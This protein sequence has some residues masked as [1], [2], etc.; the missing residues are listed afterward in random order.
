MGDTRL[1]VR[2]RTASYAVPEGF[3]ITVTHV[4]GCDN[5]VRDEEMLRCVRGANPKVLPELVSAA[6]AVMSM[7]GCPAGCHVNKDSSGGILFQ[8]HSQDSTFAG[9]LTSSG[10]STGT[11]SLVGERLLEGR[12]DDSS[13]VQALQVG[14]VSQFTSSWPSGISG[15]ASSEKAIYRRMKLDRSSDE[16]YVPSSIVVGDVAMSLGDDKTSELNG[17]G[18]SRHAHSGGTADSVGGLPSTVPYSVSATQDILGALA[19]YEAGVLPPQLSELAS[20]I[21]EDDHMDIVK[22]AQISGPEDEVLPDLDRIVR[23]EK[24]VEEDRD[25]FDRLRDIVEELEVT[26]AD[27]SKWKKDV[28]DNGCSRCSVKQGVRTSGKVAPKVEVAIPISSSEASTTPGGSAMRAVVSGIRAAPARKSC[29]PAK[30]SPV[31]QVAASPAVPVTIVRKPTYT[32]SDESRVTKSFA[33][34]AASGMSAG[35][36]SIVRGRK[37]FQEK[38]VRSPD[39][40]TSIPVRARHLTIRFVRARDVKS[41]LPVGV[42]VGK[43]RDAL[44]NTLF[45]LNCGAYFSMASLGKWGDVLLTLAATDVGDIVG[46]YPA[47]RETMET[48]GL[49]EFGF[50]RD[51]EK[52]KVFVGM[53]PLSHFGGG[54]KPSDWEGRTAFDR[55]AADI[56]QSNPGVVLAA[57]PSWAG[58][59]HKLAERRGNNAGLILVLE[60]SSEVRKIMGCNDPRLVVA[61]RPRRCR[62][63]REDTPTVVCDKCYTVG[64]RS[65]ECRSKPACAFCH[66]GHLTAHHKCPVLSCRKVGTVCPHVNRSCLLCHSDEHFAGHRDCAAL[67]GSSSSPPVLGNAT[68]VVADHTSV[69]GVS[70]ASRGR[71]RRQAAG[72]PGTPLAS[73]MINNGISGVGITEIK[74]RSE[75]NPSRADHGREVFLSRPDKGKGIARSPSAPADVSRTGGNVTLSQW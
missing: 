62:M 2:V 68:P 64:H 55:M 25:L 14:C 46:Y 67:R 45:G 49:G 70:D 59:L 75:I 27:L 35:G 37:R 24:G 30:S 41:V 53:V 3:S 54:W 40:I 43:I 26:V 48:L 56:E 28:V 20:S 39:P 7:M 4:G 42:T 31:V 47:M 58:R 22:S 38:R 73:H 18:D 36:Y 71:L 9:S 32:A 60:M 16:D 72:R 6:K 63:W 1:L 5:A 34:V 17:L 52:V 19:E 21:G 13:G 74:P 15:L 23:L 65:G 66:G 10:L 57:R 51:T 29:S 12:Q 61:G 44:N 33:S 8:D 50:A 11:G 69:V